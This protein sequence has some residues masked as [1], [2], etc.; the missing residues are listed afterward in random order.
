LEKAVLLT[1]ASVLRNVFHNLKYNGCLD[2]RRVILI[3]PRTRLS[4]DKTAQIKLHAGAKL[5][6]GYFPHIF[7]TPAPAQLRMGTDSRLVVRPGNCTVKAGVVMFIAPRATVTLGKD[8][9]IV[10]NTRVIA[11]ADIEIGDDCII[12]WESQ[13]MSGDG[14]PVYKDGQLINAP[15]PIKI[16]NHV[17]IG[18][19]AVILKGVT[20]GDGAIVAANAVVTRDVPPGAVVAGNPAK[21]VQD[22]IT[23]EL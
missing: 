7:V 15:R 16:G 9:T 5:N 13:L 4:L 21:V 20:V 23:W 14:H 1:P 17:W 3:S 11:Y 22:N 6:M 19:R 12:G 2:R 18:S 8:L 10:S